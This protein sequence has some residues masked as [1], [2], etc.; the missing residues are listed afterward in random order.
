[1]EASK[2]PPEPPKEEIVPFNLEFSSE[3]NL[4]LSND[5]LQDIKELGSGNG[6]TVSLSKHRLAKIVLARKVMVYPRPSP[7]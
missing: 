2:P 5:V 7:C 6:G 4:Q 1:M 3:L